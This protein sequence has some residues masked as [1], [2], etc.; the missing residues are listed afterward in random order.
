MGFCLKITFP[1]IPNNIRPDKDSL[2]PR[3]ALSSK[4]NQNIAVPKAQAIQS[5][6]P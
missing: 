6:V 1:P 5:R 2:L 3:L 4:C